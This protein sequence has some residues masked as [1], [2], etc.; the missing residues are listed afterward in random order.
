METAISENTA[1]WRFE[2]STVLRAISQFVF[3]NG[4]LW[5][6][7]PK[8]SGNGVPNAPHMEAAFGHTCADYPPLSASPG[9]VHRPHEIPGGG[10]GVSL[11]FSWRSPRRQNT[12]K[13]LGTAVPSEVNRSVIYANKLGRQFL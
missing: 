10:A 11:R 2:D 12:A 3:P 13:V 4:H 7:S 9:E 1:E 5:N 8:L 6:I